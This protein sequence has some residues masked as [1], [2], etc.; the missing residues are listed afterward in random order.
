MT[1]HESAHEDSE[2]RFYAQ[3]DSREVEL[4]TLD[5][6]QAAFEAGQ[7]HENTF[8]CREGESEWCTLAD[9]AGL[10]EEEEEA[11]AA[12]V[13]ET[14]PPM[15]ARRPDVVSATASET[16]PPMP[17]RQPEPVA[18]ETRPAMP[19][20]RPEM[21]TVPAQRFAQSVAPVAAPQSSSGLS[22]APVTSNIDYSALDTDDE[23]SLRPKR[24]WGLVLAAAAVLAL[25]GGGTVFALNGGGSALAS[26]V[27][28]AAALEVA[29]GHSQ[30]SLSLSNIQTKPSEPAA[31]PVAPSTP[32]PVAA[33]APAADAPKAAA[34]AFSDDMK[35]ALL[36]ADKT[37]TD[38]HAKKV[39]ANSAKAS[40]APR[41]GKAAAS[42][43]FKSGGSAY[44]PLNGKL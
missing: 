37:R 3:F 8:V 22:Y 1:Q 44:D 19:S 43:G 27:P 21:N 14:R 39:K 11:E 17:A 26:A 30:A 35:A 28:N 23:V 34:P 38:K 10:G 24:R 16:R 32:E 36:A 5:E 9:I 40:T 2:D 13:L 42:G 29:A 18:A 15:P 12:P 41:R 20:R 4:M 31:A 6:L 33:V 7:I 25:A